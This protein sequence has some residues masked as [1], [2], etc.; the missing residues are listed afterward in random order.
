M[1]EKEK[2]ELQEEA[3]RIFCE[4]DND[5]V[6]FTRKAPADML[7]RIKKDIRTLEKNDIEANK[8]NMEPI[9]VVLSEEEKELIRFGKIYK[10]RKKNAKKYLVLIAAIVSL[11]AFGI[12]SAGEPKRLLK[13]VSW[14]MGGKE[15]MNVSSED[16]D[17]ISIKGCKEEE[18]YAEIENQYGIQPVRMS[19]LPEGV[20]FKYADMGSSTQLI[21]LAYSDDQEFNLSYMMWPNYRTSSLGSTIEDKILESYEMKVR[22][23]TVTIKKILVEESNINRWSVQFEYQNVQYFIRISNIKQEEVEKIIKN[24]FF[25]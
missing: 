14:N 12:T 23:V 18:T 2:R 24:L 16:E 20:E 6:S 5:W 17:I 7:D 25:Y 22:D 11:M 19:Y 3:D 13:R 4:T 8:P 1:N 15:Q 10:K 9:R 21:Y